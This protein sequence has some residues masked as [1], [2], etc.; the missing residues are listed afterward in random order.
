M[1]AWRYRK[2]GKIG[3]SGVRQLGKIGCGGDPWFTLRRRVREEERER[4][5]GCEKK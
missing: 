5:R 2:F 3:A 4:E 1:V